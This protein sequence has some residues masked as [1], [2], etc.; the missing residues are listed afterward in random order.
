MD[1][2]RGQAGRLGGSLRMHLMSMD[3]TLTPDITSV[4]SEMATL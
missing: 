4:A 2:R 3:E 1:D